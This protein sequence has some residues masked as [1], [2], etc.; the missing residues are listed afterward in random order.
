MTVMKEARLHTARF[1]EFVLS[2][3]GQ[4]IIA[5]HGFAPAVAR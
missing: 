4:E 5:R 2:R 3:P 1:A